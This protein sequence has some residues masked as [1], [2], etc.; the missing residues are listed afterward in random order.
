M[1]CEYCAAM[2]SM[3]LPTHATEIYMRAHH[4]CGEEG[5][6]YNPE[7][8]LWVRDNFSPVHDFKTTWCQVRYIR[9]AHLR[10]HHERGDTC[11]IH[12]SV[13]ARM[14]PRYGVLMARILGQN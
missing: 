5:N 13:K 2:R 4:E 1:D 3:S 11:E 7:F 9:M 8:A 10:Y 6:A 12:E 14:G